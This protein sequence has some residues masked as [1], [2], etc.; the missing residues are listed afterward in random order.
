M[1]TINEQ[2]AQIEE[3]QSIITSLQERLDKA[4]L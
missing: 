3:H 1:I 4:G 2:Q